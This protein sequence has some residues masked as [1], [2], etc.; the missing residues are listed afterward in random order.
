MMKTIASL[1]C[2]LTLH[3][4][5]T[6]T[7]EMNSYHDFLRGRFSGVSLDRDGRLT[8]APHLATV[9][10]TD[11]AAIWSLAR[12]S[13]GS[14]YLGTGHRGRVYKIS[15]AGGS[16]LLWT[17]D[18]PEIFALAVDA[19]GVLYAATSPNGKV[20]RIEHGKATE[21]FAP[22]CGYIWALAFAGDGSLFV[23]VGAPADIYRVDP[24]GHAELYYQTGQAHVTALALDGQGRLLA[25]TEPNGI[26][27]RITAR[28]KAFVLYDANLPEIRGIVAAPDG[29][30]Y[31]AA[32][33]GSVVS[34][35]GASIAAPPSS[36]SLTPTAA[37]TSITVTDA[38]AGPEIRPKPPVPAPAPASPAANAIVDISGVDKSALYKINPDNTVETLWTSKEENIYDIATGDA[39][40]LLFS[41]DAQGRIYRLSPD[42]KAALL[43]QTNEGE[44]T[45]LLRSPAGL[46]AATSDSGTLYRMAAPLDAGR[47]ANGA[48]E[49]PVHDAGT[50]A[51]WG[52]LTWR[53]EGNAAFET[54]TGNSAR[55]DRTW[56]EWS[57]VP[58]PDGSGPVQSPNA[59]F[60]QW[61][62]TLTGDAQVEDAVVAYLPQNTPPVIRS[63]SVVSQAAS[64]SS[65]KNAP[66]TAAASA[67]YSITVTDTGDAP[68]T[69][70]GTPTQT[71]SRTGG[72]QMQISWQ[73]E[74][75]DG[76]KLSYTLY[77]RGEQERDWK[78]L[79]ANLQENTYSID[80]DSLADG[81]YAFRVV[82]SDL[83]SNP[84]ATARDAELTSSPVLID[85]TP[86]AVVIAASRRG[87][88][89]WEIDVDAA[90][91]ASALR[92][93][94]Y[95][96][97]AGPWIPVEAADGV[98]DSP[99]EQFHIRAEN[100]PPGEHVAAI[101]VYDA[102]G[103]AGLAKVVSR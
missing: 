77:F 83:P 5:S 36:I 43:V 6:T 70:T 95:S 88:P 14:L 40:E 65:A 51:R 24:A 28:D 9:F 80:A 58:A 25:G 69:S 31:A 103:N 8:V 89:R 45:R 35:T 68:S 27:Y 39:G 20:F 50:V 10:A 81:R 34:R 59:R 47:A 90:D 48:Y 54:R 93:C 15:P 46:L 57:A 91:R 62:A 32:L 7:W 37:T 66:A 18:Q 96:I 12:S 23:G 60:I 16:S 30:V 22:K 41:T 3:A 4:A 100:L 72:S 92:R 2:V 49:S 52:R 29:T 64:S 17:S 33:G 97:D 86:P 44:T 75:P 102:A 21:F 67:S 42:R 53:G 71:L 94:E 98:T 55:P 78:L 61:K 74:D 82:A 99:S 79:K 85:N 84:P 1:I 63:I 73:A 13:D 87:G 26:L 76:D 38:Q 101:R 19:R 56:S 11:Q